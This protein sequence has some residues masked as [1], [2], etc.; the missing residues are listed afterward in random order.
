MRFFL[1]NA[2]ATFKSQMNSVLVALKFAEVHFYLDNVLV[3]AETYN[4][5]LSL[6]A[7]FLNNIAQQVFAVSIWNYSSLREV[8]YLSN[9][10]EIIENNSGSDLNRLES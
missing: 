4:K 10:V 3:I 5:L 6:W 9:I 8:L 7:S 2:I 1:A